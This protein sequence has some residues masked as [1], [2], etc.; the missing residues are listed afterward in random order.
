[1]D[2]H[3]TNF[4]LIEDYFE[5]CQCFYYQSEHEVWLNIS[6]MNLLKNSSQ[7]IDELEKILQSTNGTCFLTMLDNEYGYVKVYFEKGNKVF[8]CNYLMD[9]HYLRK[10]NQELRDFFYEAKKNP[11][12]I[13]KNTY[14][15]MEENCWDVYC[16]LYP[17]TYLIVTP[18]C[19][20]TLD[21]YFQKDDQQF[22]HL[23]DNLLN[24][25]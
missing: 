25:G 18:Y 11:Y 3:C 19:F 16:D 17:E 21:L 24:L 15:S 5:D 14:D 2:V 12:P 4:E 22:I 8:Y 10:N 1:M 6:H 7:I 23:D 9:M 13:L 20:E